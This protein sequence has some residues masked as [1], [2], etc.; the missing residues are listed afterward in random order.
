MKKIWK[1]NNEW[2]LGYLIIAFIIFIIYL[3]INSD[4]ATSN[5]ENLQNKNYFPKVEIFTK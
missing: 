1:R 2:F 5:L 4:L 3:W